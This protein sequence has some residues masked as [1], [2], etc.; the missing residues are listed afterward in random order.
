MLWQAVEKVSNRHSGRNEG[1]N[2]ESNG[3]RIAACAASGMT[4]E[5]VQQP[6]SDIAL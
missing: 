1:A 4:T 3:F 2:P 6:A 5:I